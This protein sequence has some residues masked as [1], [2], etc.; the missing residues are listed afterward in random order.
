MTGSRP[1]PDAE[2]TLP[3]DEVRRMFEELKSDFGSLK[4]EFGSLK[5]EF[6]SLRSELGSKVDTTQ[7]NFQDLSAQVA[8]DRDIWLANKENH[9]TLNEEF[10]YVAGK[11][12]DTSS[13]D[14]Y[15]L[16]K[17]LVFDKKIDKGKMTL[18]K[19]KIVC[20]VVGET[21]KKEVADN[22]L[23]IIFNSSSVVDTDLGH[24]GKGLYLLISLMNHS[25]LPN[26]IVVFE[27]NRAF[28]RAVEPIAEGA[29]ICQSYINLSGS[30]M[31]RK[32]TLE[33]EYLFTCT[34]P[35]C[36]EGE[37]HDILE[38]AYVEGYRCSA[39][40]CDGALLSNS[41]IDLSVIA[42]NLKDWKEALAYCKLIIEQYQG[43]C[44]GYNVLLGLEYYRCGKFQG[45][46]RDAENAVISLNKAIDILQIAY[47]RDT[48]FMKDLFKRLEVQQ[49]LCSSSQK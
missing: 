34:C 12:I 18:G 11:V 28:V 4:N 48:A 6:G 38:R 43:L 10:N 9:A 22:L 8:K 37:H 31:S 17:A 16:V 36:I 2:P 33:G 25:C 24:L 27:G 14:N 5:N 35:R 1:T 44:P 41:G 42:M 3:A 30:T 29:E 26:C 46:L 39:N 32:M 49:K 13:L 40:G 45:A 47:G 15:A 23:R 20:K 21:N 19:A 7:Q